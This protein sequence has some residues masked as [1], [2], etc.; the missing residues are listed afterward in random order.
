VKYIYLWKE[1]NGL[2]T[3]DDLV[4]SP[5]PINFVIPAKAGIQ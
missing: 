2:L 4:K 1:R 3:I 5:I